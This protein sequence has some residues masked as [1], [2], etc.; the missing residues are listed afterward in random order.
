MKAMILATL[1]I[2]STLVVQFN[3]FKKALIVLITIPLALIGVFFGMFVFK[4]TLSFPGLIGILALFGIVVKNAIILMDKIN[5]NLKTGIEFKSA[6]VDAGKSRLEA[7]FITS[8]CTIFGI[9]PITL[10]DETWKALG[11]AVIFGLMVSSFLTLFIVPT[12]FV[13]LIKE[14]PQK[15]A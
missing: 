15:V 5:L 11:S 13:S 3:S 10:S 7:I 9:L 12:L 8:I 4:I 1:L 2:I 14:K 6:I